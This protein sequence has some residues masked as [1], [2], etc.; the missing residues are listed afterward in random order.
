V[1]RAGDAR[2][3][4]GLGSGELFAHGHQ[5]G[6]FGF[7]D[8]ISLRPQAAREISVMAESAGLKRTAAFMVFSKS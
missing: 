7:G 1:Q 3:L 2:A 6:H 4:Q 8:L 5:A